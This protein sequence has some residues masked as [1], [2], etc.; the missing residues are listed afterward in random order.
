M[1][2]LYVPRHSLCIGR[3]TFCILF[4]M[5][6]R[7]ETAYPVKASGDWF[8]SSTWAGGAA[9]SRAGAA[10][11]LPSGSITLR[12]MTNDVVV[13]HF[14][15][16][17]TNSSSMGAFLLG[18]DWYGSCKA[19]DEYPSH[20]GW[21]YGVHRPGTVTFEKDAADDH[22]TFA[23]DTPESKRGSPNGSYMAIL[24][25]VVLKSDLAIRGIGRKD[26][27]QITQPS[28]TMGILGPISESGGPY[29]ITVDVGTPSKVTDPCAIYGPDNDFTG[30]VHVERGLLRAIPRDEIAD[31][32]TAPF[33]HDN[34][35]YATNG[36]G[37]IDI[38]PFKTGLSQHLY[39]GGKMP[40]STYGQLFSIYGDPAFF[41]EWAG[42]ITLVTNA[43]VGGYAPNNCLTYA[44]SNLVL[45]GPIDDGG[46]GY[47]LT[48]YGASLNRHVVLT[49][50]NTYSGGT[51][52]GGNTRL[53]ALEHSLGTGRVSFSGSG[54]YRYNGPQSCD[55]SRL[56]VSGV[57]K[58]EVP[59]GVTYEPAESLG[60]FSGFQKHGRGT[61]VLAHENKNSNGQPEVYDG[62]LVFDYAAD[63]GLR[64]NN[65]QS[66]FFSGKTTLLVRNRPSDATVVTH[67]LVV[68]ANSWCDFINES[69]G[70]KFKISRL[71]A[72]TGR[73]ANIVTP[74][75]FLCDFSN[76]GATSSTPG[77]ISPSILCRGR[78]WAKKAS[79]GTFEEFTDFSSAWSTDSTYRPVVDISSGNASAPAGAI[80]SCIRFNDPSCGTLV[81][82]GDATLYGG[83][84]LVTEAMG[85]TPV[86][87]R[88][89]RLLTGSASTPI[90]IINM[91][92]NAPV[93]IES[94]I[95]VVDNAAGN[96]C[97]VGPGTVRLHGDNSF[98][99]SLYVN[100]CNLEIDRGSAIG[101]V[102]SANGAKALSFG[103]NVTMTFTGSMILAQPAASGTGV[104]KVGMSHGRYG[105]TFSI[106]NA[107]DVV[108]VTTN[109]SGVGEFTSSSSIHETPLVFSGPG[110]FAW[111]LIGKSN[112]GIVITNGA[113]IAPASLSNFL[114]DNGGCR[115]V[116]VHAGTTLRSS[117]FA[118]AGMVFR[119]SGSGI[120][121]ANA[122]PLRF[123]GD[124]TLDVKGGSPTL[125]GRIASLGSYTQ[126]IDAWI[127]TGTV[128]IV[129]S[130][131]TAASISPSG[132]R[133]TRISGRIVSDIP[134]NGE[135]GMK[136]PDVEFVAK[137]GVNH[138]FKNWA[139]NESLWFGALSGSGGFSTRLSTY[140]QNLGAGAGGTDYRAQLFF[141]GRDRPDE[142]A[143]YSGV[144][145]LGQFNDT[146]KYITS[147]S[148]FAYRGATR[149]IKIGTN[150]QR[151]SGTWNWIVGAPI[152]RGGRL[153]IGADSIPSA[154]NGYR[155]ALGK[156]MV[157]VGDDGTAAG[158]EPRLLIDGGYTVANPVN[159]PSISPAGALPGVG[160]TATCEYTGEV[161]LFR[162]AALV[163]EGAGSVVTFDTVAGM[164]GEDENQRAGIV[165]TGAGT[166]V[167]KSLTGVSDFGCDDAGGL[168]TVED[169]IVLPA[170]ARFVFTG[171]A[172]QLDK[173]R[174]VIVSADSISGG[175]ASVEGLPDGW[176]LRV[177]ARTISLGQA[178]GTVLFLR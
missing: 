135:G 42:S 11:I 55:I 175:F 49:G 162:Q 110:T 100:N 67:Y 163:A 127:G 59:E 173:T 145:D 165:M 36:L 84:I 152:V 172:R 16:P 87:I 14:L 24:H 35:I 37:A 170:D 46:K 62:T 47:S 154:A 101:T 44:K 66:C 82:G 142:V 30:D 118:Q 20:N 13:G 171:D 120:D 121:A 88:G 99:G 72:N 40:C 93:T 156:A 176:S 108:T 12:R 139:E 92:T 51:V 164:Q 57:P 114:H 64:Y 33:G 60:A 68:R 115:P 61:L 79:G 2:H 96:V 107:S 43:T 124:F 129:N 117:G 119:G 149:L 157:L 50:A 97:I 15:Y 70:A 138:W 167:I 29:G 54:I 150:T 137:A 140:N 31:G 123:T 85:S 144:L 86:T 158:A 166:V 109:L 98:L 77:F 73:I 19:T 112:D 126:F 18:N 69:E 132:F 71:T 32:F 83:A 41:P 90:H 8:S 131:A 136:L 39:I 178:G 17:S 22:A 45:S 168:L 116:T 63:S 65:T 74:D 111:D 5:S 1:R 146:N 34:A 155:G 78:S 122:M 103:V 174:H 143:D 6:A 38:G 106:P 102:A 105:V 151:I 89:G 28:Y 104:A 48:L 113:T 91:N 134:F 81:L 141:L 58:F 125:G 27:N 25:P 56:G 4:A 169:D 147:S 3:F 53:S 80:A 7:S 76:G 26:A 153:L 177:G 9:P 130:S 159:V 10:V 75:T 128:S 52:V 133:G 161:K 95:A 94:D 21:T 148:T 160:G 23:N